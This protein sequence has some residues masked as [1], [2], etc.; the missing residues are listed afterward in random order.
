MD[1]NKNKTKKQPASEKILDVAEKLFYE[2]GI[3]AVGIDKIIKEANVAMNTMYK[4]FPSKD[5]L[6]ESY[7]KKRDIKWMEWL[8]G[9]VDKETQ[10]KE[11]IMA[12]FDALDWWFKD[13]AYRGCAFINASGE[14]GGIKPFVHKISKAHKEKIYDKILQILSDTDIKCKQKLAKQIM[15]LIEGA[16]VRAYINEDKDA[17]IYAKEVLE[18]ILGSSL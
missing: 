14:I 4:Y 1:E 12:I 17:A 2:E 11:K 10:P 7:L 13:D 16:I 5:I 18:I 15:T 3:Q 6:I 8:N 9:Y